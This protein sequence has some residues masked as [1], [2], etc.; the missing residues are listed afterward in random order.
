MLESFIGLQVRHFIKFKIICLYLFVIIIIIIVVVV[1]NTPKEDY[2][3]ESVAKLLATR[4]EDALVLVWRPVSFSIDYKSVFGNLLRVG[5]TVKHIHDV[6]KSALDQLLSREPDAELVL[7][8][9]FSRINLLG[10]S[11][12]CIVINQILSEVRIM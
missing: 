9:A 1:V 8:E 10:F 3:L 2:S 11:A 4:Y 6:L 5:V 12:A 7:N